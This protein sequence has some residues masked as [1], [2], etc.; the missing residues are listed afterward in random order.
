[1]FDMGKI[2]Y[3]FNKKEVIIRESGMI[4]SREIAKPLFLFFYLSM[5]YFYGTLTNNKLT[6]TFLHV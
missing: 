2:Q 1:M 6:S 4:D 3:T 5:F